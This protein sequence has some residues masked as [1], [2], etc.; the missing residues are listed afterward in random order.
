MEQKTN[1]VILEP[2]DPS[3]IFAGGVGDDLPDV[4]PFGDW[5]P[6]RPKFET[7]RKFGM[8]TMN[9]VQA[10]RAALCG[11]MSAFHGRTLNLSER[12]W[13]WLCGCTER[14]NSFSACDSGIRRGGGCR[15]ELW[16]WD[17]Q[18]TR[19]E[20]GIEPPDGVKAEA[21]KL[22]EEWVFGRLRW[23]PTDVAAMK[24]AL[25]KTPLWFCNSGHAM[26]VERI[27]DR[28]R[29]WDTEANGTGGP[30][31]FPL[32]YVSQIVAA[33]N[34]PF[35]PKDLT[36]KPM[37]NVKLKENTKVF[38]CE[39]LGRHALKITSA[40]GIEYLVA[41]EPAKVLAQFI[42][43]NSKDGMFSGGPAVTLKTAD[44]DSFPHATFAE[45]SRL[46]K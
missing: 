35:S 20:Y 22:F 13:Y 1:H 31:S 28:I 42:D 40:K 46:N 14:G 43:R 25:R 5:T 19:A 38:E 41:D 17:R 9:C 32:D 12:L 16:P 36:D 24:A 4:N 30:G 15:E 6:Y 10:S 44:F 37:P 27:D 11:Y 39:G 2:I 8:D 29:V 23:V 7:Q 18:M 3:L 26:V 45:F 34:A 33:Y 21:L